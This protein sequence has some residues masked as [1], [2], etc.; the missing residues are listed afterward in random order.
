M[1]QTAA[2][3]E[4]TLRATDRLD[5]TG[6]VRWYR[7]DEDRT[8]F[9]DGIFGNDDNGKTLVSN[10]GTTKANG[11]APRVIASFKASDALTL[12]AQV[13]KGFRLGG[14]N[15]P[16]N[17]PLCTQT[18]LATFSGRNSWQDEKAWNYEVGAKSRLA[19]GK[20][21]LNVSAYTMDITDLQLT[22]TAGSCSSRLVFNVPKAVSRGAEVELDAVPNEHVAL[23]L[24]GTFNDSK[25]RSTLTSTNAQGAVAVVSGISSG[26][27]LPSVP[28]VQG[29][30]ALTLRR[31]MLASQGFVTGSVQHVGS[32]YT[33]IDDLAAGF[34]AVDL[35]SFGKNT[36]GGPLTQS[37]FRF[38]PLLPAYTLVNLRAGLTRPAW[39]LAVYVNNVGDTRA[40]L[41]LDR[42]RGTRARVGYLTNQ[43]RTVGV[44]L[45]FRR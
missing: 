40:L 32:R 18:D 45:G 27:R 15:D 11:V 28:R 5:V 30:A 16:L 19:D 8:Q 41:A 37:T 38:D 17:V 1:N 2:F 24:S 6:G 44:S 13:A 22:V 9:F 3:G 4:A 7:F 39:D 23:S 29:A 36:I 31:P 26:N 42:E 20:V 33:Q 12:N 21:S 34:G 10:P 35:N 43:A 14:I 25:L